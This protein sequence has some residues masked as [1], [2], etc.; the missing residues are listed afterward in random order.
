MHHTAVERQGKLILFGGRAS[1]AKPLNDLI[2]IDLTSFNV[3]NITVDGSPPSP[4]WGHTSILVGTKMIVIGGRNATSVLSDVHILDLSSKTPSWKSGACGKPMF[5]HSAVNVK[6]KIYCFGGRS[7]LDAL[8]DISLDTIHVYDSTLDN[9]SIE[10]TSGKTIPSARSNTQAVI[11]QD[12]HVILT[13]GT[14]SLTQCQSDIFSLNLSR[15]IWQQHY[16]HVENTIWT[17]HSM[18][19]DTN[20]STCLISGGSVQCFGF[21]AIYSPIYSLNISLEPVANKAVASGE[22]KKNTANTKELVLVIEK[23]RVK[24]MKTTLEARGFYDKQRRIQPVEGSKVAFAVPVVDAILHHNEED[25]PILREHL[26]FV[27]PKDAAASCNIPI[28]NE[29]PVR[30]KKTVKPAQESPKPK[31]AKLPK[32]SSKAKAKKKSTANLPAKPAEAQANSTYGFI[33]SKESVKSVK[34]A[35]EA[36]GIYDKTRRIHAHMNEDGVFVVPLLTKEI[37]KDIPELQGHEVIEDSESTRKPVLNPNVLV[38]GILKKYADELGLSNVPEKFEYI[39][40]IL[41]LPKNSCLDAKWNDSRIWSEVS[42]AVP[43]I[44]RV[45][46]NADVNEN[47]KRQSR[48]TLLFVHPSFKGSR[49]NGWVEIR[50]NGLYYGWNIEKVMF[51]SGNVTEKARMAQI[52]CANETIVDMYA[53]IGYYVI[54]FLVHGKAAH[55]HALEWNPDSVECL[56][57]NLNRNHVSDR[58]TVYQGDN[59]ITGP[60]L[61]A[62]ADRVNLGLLPT[63]EHGWPVAVQV[64]K[65]TGGMLH[66]HENVAIDNLPAWQIYVVNSIKTLAAGIGKEWTHVVL[67]A[68][69]EQSAIASPLDV[70]DVVSRIENLSYLH[71][72]RVEC[73]D[74]RYTAEALGLGRSARVDD[75]TYLRCVAQVLADL[76]RARVDSTSLGMTWECINDF[77]SLRSNE[78]RALG[79]DFIDICLDLHAD[80]VTLPLR[81]SIFQALIKGQNDCLRRQKALRSVLQDGRLVVPFVNDLGPYLLKLL[82][83][84]DAQKELMSLLH[85]ILRRSPRALD[86]AVLTEM[87]TYLA[88]RSNSAMARGDTATCKRFLKFVTML[89]T[90]RL[91]MAANSQVCLKTMCGLVNM[92]GDGVGAWAIMKHLLAGPSGYHFI[93]GLLGL[94]E[95]RETSPYILR[96]AIFYVGMSCWGSQRIPA[97]EI[98]WGTILISLLQAAAINHGVVVFEMVIS[99]QRL[100]KKYGEQMHVEWDIVYRFFDVLY[101]WMHFKTGNSTPSTST[102]FT[103]DRIAEELIEILRLMDELVRLK[104]FQGDVDGFF[105]VV[106]MYL[107]YCPEE[108]VLRLVRHQAWSCH[109]ANNIHWSNCLSDLL[110]KYFSNA[111]LPTQVRLEALTVLNDI[112][113][114][115]RYVCEDQILEYVYIPRLQHIY[116]DENSTVRRTGLENIIQHAKHVESS[117]CFALIDILHQSV[118]SAKFPDAQ[119]IAVNGIVSLFSSLFTEVPLNRAIYLY[120]KLT[121][122]CATHR[123]ATIRRIATTCLLHVSTANASYQ[124]QWIENH[125][126]QTS[127]L[128]YSSRAVVGSHKQMAYLP[129]AKAVTAFLSMASTE[130]NA[131]IFELVIGGIHQMLENRFILHDIDLSEMVLKLVSCVECRAFGRAAIGDGISKTRLRS[132]T[133]SENSENARD[134]AQWMELSAR[135][136]N[137]GFELLLLLAS[138]DSKFTSTA[139]VRLMT[140]FVHGLDIQPTAL[141]WEKIKSIQNPFKRATSEMHLGHNQVDSLQLAE[142]TLTH[143]ITSGLSL[144]ALMVDVHEALPIIIHAIV[145]KSCKTPNDGGSLVPKM[146]MMGLEM[147]LNLFRA[148]KSVMSTLIESDM[149]VVLGFALK[150]LQLPGGSKQLYYLA[151][152]LL[153][154]CFTD[155]PMALRSALAAIALPLLQNLHENILEEVAMDFVKL[156]AFAPQSKDEL[157]CQSQKNNPKVLPPNA[158]STQVSWSFQNTILTMRTGFSVTQ[159]IVR[160]PTGTHQWRLDTNTMES[161]HPL[162][163]MSQLF[164]INPLARQQLSGLELLQDG[165]GLTRAMNVLDMSPSYETHKVGV[166]YLAQP[167]AKEKDV[168]DILGGSPRYVEFLRGL[169]DIVQL[170][171]LEGYNGGLD[172]SANANDGK[173]CLIYKDASMQ[174]VFHVATMMHGP[175]Q[176]TNEEDVNMESRRHGKKRHLGNDFVHLVYLDYSNTHQTHAKDDIPTLSAQFNDVQIVVQPLDELATLYRVHVRCK[177]G[178][179]QLTFGPLKGMHILPASIAMEAVRLTC[180]NANLACRVLHHQRIE[181]ILNSEDRLKQIKLIGQRFK[182]SPLV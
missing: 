54:P 84:S 138:N 41:L 148:N 64:L 141:A 26:Q 180:L 59:R 28:A 92:N 160:R 1:P 168:L 132:F 68:E 8:S 176:E 37:P 111:A 182:V 91:E 117:K 158:N 12:Q 79:F 159:I 124:M 131:P 181:Y 151:Y 170:S 81:T 57:Y 43:S 115:C 112:L 78:A 39:A 88:K 19:F 142:F 121:G 139:R 155:A 76:K 73:T 85:C 67:E 120:E 29:A 99:I 42:T 90:H 97:L 6:G 82:E 156:M 147:L 52:G 178:L 153:V 116:T 38:H 128:L 171:S 56:R 11:V 10:S 134:S 179:A 140:T 114:A 46:R 63:S 166:M 53:G 55:V 69:K 133:D 34:T 4:R 144:L 127:R 89:S 110:L 101:P 136:L 103:P 51:S 14:S 20:S 75:K 72:L 122:Y 113:L 174:V 9:W 74:L 58:C 70:Q 157:I 18:V 98:S 163:V 102:S 106:E 7:N 17:S 129:I 65:S 80:R 165:D 145:N 62:I 96:G 93:R 152:L 162:H 130:S 47:E 126:I 30:P 164:D 71:Q 15:M 48:V 154:R 35:L 83:V 24:T 87:A 16:P 25:D 27:V 5:V 107:E 108:A 143:T 95:E 77:L 167:H 135:Y 109:P 175:L 86:I 169:G 23:V 146:V 177:P 22:Q 161:A 50:E 119:D 94:L 60:T 44:H 172:T 31:K 137:R 104:R 45:A 33:V 2:S 13:G 125:E 49:G 3:E 32:V 123:N 105:K 173:Y 149:V 150:A 118:I 40:D 61:G 66:V 21:G 100:I 36:L